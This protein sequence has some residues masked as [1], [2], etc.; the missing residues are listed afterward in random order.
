VVFS[1]FLH[2][3]RE[4]LQLNLSLAEVVIGFVFSSRQVLE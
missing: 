2:C 3:I 1:L 4:A